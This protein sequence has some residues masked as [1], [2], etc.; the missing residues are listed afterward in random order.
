MGRVSLKS[1]I[2]FF[3]LLPSIFSILIRM[4]RLEAFSLSLAAATLS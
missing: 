1:F 3:P 2:I 4:L